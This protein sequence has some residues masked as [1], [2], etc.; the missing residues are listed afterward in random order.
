MYV[1]HVRYILVCILLNEVAGKGLNLNP[2]KKLA[3]KHKGKKSTQPPTIVINEISTGTVTEVQVGHENLDDKSACDEIMAKALLRASEEKEIAFAERDEALGQAKALSAK[4]DELL[5]A[6]EK[7]MEDA[8]LATSEYEAVKLMAEGLVDDAKKNASAQIEKVKLDSESTIA[9]LN[10]AFALK[11]NEW[12]EEKATLIKS[13]EEEAQRKLDEM[14]GLSDVNEK[15]MNMKVLELRKQVESIMNA[16]DTEIETLKKSYE[17]EI[18]DIRIKSSEETTRLVNDAIKQRDEANQLL[19]KML[20]ESKLKVDTLL[21]EREELVSNLRAT[22]SE[23]LELAKQRSQQ[24]METLSKDYESKLLQLRDEL[25]NTKMT[26]KNREETFELEFSHYKQ[27][28]ARIMKEF[29]E[30]KQQIQTAKD[31][32]MYWVKLHQQQGYVNITLV[33]E[34]VKELY[35][36]ASAKMKTEMLAAMK[37]ASV[38]SDEL[39]SQLKFQSKILLSK[40]R[41]MTKSLKDFVT[42]L[43]NAH[44]ASG[45]DASI[46]QTKLF[47]DRHLAK[48]ID[49]S[50]SS[51]NSFYEIYLNKT[52]EGSVKPFYIQ[53]IKPLKHKIDNEYII[54]YRKTVFLWL[55]KLQ[56]LLKKQATEATAKVSDIST[57]LLERLQN[58]VKSMLSV[59]LLALNEKESVPSFFTK[60]VEYTLSQSEILVTAVLSLIGLFIIY[61]LRRML[62]SSLIWTLCLPF[63]LVWYICPL[64]LLVRDDDEYEEGIIGRKL[65]SNSNLKEVTVKE[66]GSPKPKKK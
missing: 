44:L 62:L 14:K 48:T 65:K 16:K 1:S 28:N 5:R 11:E 38:K 39:W 43:Y 25:T 26:L 3:E 61:K 58:S 18:K 19:N 2:F 20:E 41:E 22:S 40:A 9:D 54:P 56:V 30:L 10:K 8:K 4:A 51:A 29:N 36:K 42:S 6:T 50:V 66:N 21:K 34:D 33:Q 63:Q 45:V 53:R 7:A 24:E 37:H 47:Y 31:E 57:E 13:M 55:Y 59:F 52:V 35:D 64:R 15:E 32:T 46:S 17:E 23:Q 49:A 27:E 60:L 12:L